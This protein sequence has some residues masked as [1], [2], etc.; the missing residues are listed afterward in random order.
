VGVV[1]GVAGGYLWDHVFGDGCYTWA[2]AGRDAA[3]GAAFGGVGKAVGVALGSATKGSSWSYGAHKSAQKWAS[4]MNK[5][6]WTEQQITE[7]IKRGKKYPAP[8]YPNPANGATRYVHPQTGRS[9]VVDD[10]TKEIIQVGD[11]GFKY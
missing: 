5:R 6:G 10:V 7:A 1:V 2:D 3:I 9:V 8:N 11:N 4:Q